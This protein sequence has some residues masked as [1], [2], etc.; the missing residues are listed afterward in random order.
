[1]GTAERKGEE[2]RRREMECKKGKYERGRER[3]RRLV[4]GSTSKKRV[5]IN[6]LS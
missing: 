3:R 6:E 5:G 2:E 1:M 4:P